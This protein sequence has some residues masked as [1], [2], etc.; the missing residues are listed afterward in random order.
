MRPERRANPDAD[1]ESRRRE[2]SH[3]DAVDYLHPDHD[4]TRTGFCYTTAHRYLCQSDARAHQ[5]TCADNDP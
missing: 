1:A 3:A 5:H 4:H 2:Q